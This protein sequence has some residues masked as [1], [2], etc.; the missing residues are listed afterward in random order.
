MHEDNPVWNL[1]RFAT[2]V[3]CAHGRNRRGHDRRTEALGQIC[4]R[5][6]HG[7][8]VGSAQRRRLHPRGI[9]RLEQA[10]RRERSARIEMLLKKIKNEPFESELPMEVWDDAPRRRR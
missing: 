5:L 2:R 9:R 1:S 7:E 3:Y 6:A 4:V 8:T 10:D